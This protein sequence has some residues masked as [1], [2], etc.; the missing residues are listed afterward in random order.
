M[1]EDKVYQKLDRLL[2]G[3]F[4]PL[5]GAATPGFEARVMARIMETRREQSF[6]DFLREAA[7]PILV[8]G[9]A[10]AALLAFVALKGLGESRDIALAALVNGDAVSRWLVL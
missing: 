5:E 6:W 3:V 10:T 2:S 8:S 9:W 1:N 7:S 4:A